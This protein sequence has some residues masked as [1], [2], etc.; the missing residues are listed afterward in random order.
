MGITASSVITILARWFPGREIDVSRADTGVSTP[1]FRVQIDD[2]PLWAR[3]GEK[4]GV[5]APSVRI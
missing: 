1:V 4:S 5:I 3:L 2:E